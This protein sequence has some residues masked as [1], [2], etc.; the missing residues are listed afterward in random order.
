M[1]LKNGRKRFGD[2]CESTS[3]HAIPDFH[4]AETKCGKIFWILI[5]I[6]FTSIC[7]YEIWTVLSGY[8]NDDK[9]STE[10]YYEHVKNLEFP[11]ISICYG[12]PWSKRAMEKL[13]MSVDALD[14]FSQIFVGA[15]NRTAYFNYSTMIQMR[16]TYNEWESSPIAQNYCIP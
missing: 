16:D 8:I 7:A 4:K 13:N 10:T 12:N 6:I 14:Y 9:Y 3:A 15:V 2:W 5:L 11:S 1:A